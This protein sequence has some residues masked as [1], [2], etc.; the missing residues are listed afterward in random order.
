MLG[1]Q[2]VEEG[3]SAQKERG[4]TAK[5]ENAVRQSGPWPFGLPT[6]GAL[7]VWRAMV[8]D[9]L[10]NRTNVLI[11]CHTFR[12]VSIL[13]NLGYQIVRTAVRRGGHLCKVWLPSAGR[14]KKIALPALLCY[15]DL[16]KSP[17]SYRPARGAGKRW[18]GLPLQGCDSTQTTHSQD[19]MGLLFWIR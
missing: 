7:K 2:R 11:L 5:K 8:L 13:G 18:W 3:G 12:A 15:N 14:R 19:A 9:A 17:H 1:I 16:Y 4:D 10:V 6:E